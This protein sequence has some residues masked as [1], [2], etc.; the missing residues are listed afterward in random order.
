MLKNPADMQMI[1]RRQNSRPFLAKVSPASLLDVSA[2]YFQ[3]GLVE[4]SAMIRS[5]TGK[6][7]R[8]KWSQCMGH[9]VRYH[10]ATVTVAAVARINMPSPLYAVV[11]SK[12]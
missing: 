4:E 3:R 8:Q 1:L 12:T 9:L 10:L 11:F 2:G 6:E 5:Q 7:S